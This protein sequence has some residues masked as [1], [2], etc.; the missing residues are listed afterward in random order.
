[1]LA[2]VEACWIGLDVVVDRRADLTAAV[3]TALIDRGR[4]YVLILFVVEATKEAP[5][6]YASVVDCSLCQRLIHISIGCR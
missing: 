4:A 5:V 3:A 2:E 1:M 6:Y